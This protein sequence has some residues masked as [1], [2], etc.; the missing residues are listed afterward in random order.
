M[1]SNAQRS[2]LNARNVLDGWLLSRLNQTIKSVTQNLN[3]YDAYRACEA[4]EEFVDD[5]SN[6]Y[7]RRSRDRVGPTVEDNK[8]KILFYETTFYTLT[9]LCLILS[10]FTPFMTDVIFRNLTKEESVH[11]ASWP[12]LNLKIDVNLV[13]QMKVIREIA[14][15]VHGQRKDANLPVRQPLQSISVK[16]PKIR[17]SND[18]L[19]LLLS[20]INVKEIIWIKGKIMEVVLDKNISKLLEEEGKARELVRY[21]QNERRNMGIVLTQK[22]LVC[23]P[24]IPSNKEI[25]RWVINKTLAKKLIKGEFKITKAS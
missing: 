17:P 7:I 21:I 20:E 9:K 16:S 10:P 4:I 15:I 23:S 8:S 1:P 22:V 11:L 25:T 13:K 2:T 24:W 14:E 18:L 3:D 19:S 6:W 5:F 12:K